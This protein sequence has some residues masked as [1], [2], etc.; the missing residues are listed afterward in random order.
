M[1]KDGR[2]QDKEV[3]GF[4]PAQL[5][6]TFTGDRMR[7]TSVSAQG[8]K[9]VR[10]W[11]FR[12]EPSTKPKRITLIEVDGG[13]EMTAIYKIERDTLTMCRG[14]AG[15]PVP[16][17]FATKPGDKRK[18]GVYKREKVPERH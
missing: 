12:L 2:A 9:L 15:Q 11:T 8:Q 3:T 1:E 6:M 5:S 7:A 14:Y 4:D 18:L 17:D 10:E 13:T 16:T